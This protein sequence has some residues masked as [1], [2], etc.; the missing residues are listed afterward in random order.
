MTA[1]GNDTSHLTVIFP[2]KRKSNCYKIL[3]KINSGGGLKEGAGLAQAVQCLATG[4]TTG[5]SEF[6]PGVNKGFFL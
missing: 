1:Y 5:Q 4:W 2:K 3:S 6:D